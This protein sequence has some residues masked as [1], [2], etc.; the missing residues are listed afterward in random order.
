MFVLQRVKASRR[1]KEVV[2]S[3]FRRK[4][5]TKKNE[6]MNH[7]SPQSQPQKPQK[8]KVFVQYNLCSIIF[9]V[10]KV[11]TNGDSRSL[12][13]D[14]LQIYTRKVVLTFWLFS[15]INFSMLLLLRSAF[16]SIVNTTWFLVGVFENK[17]G[18]GPS[19]HPAQVQTGKVL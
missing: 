12:D 1:S 3:T 19:R 15:L 14:M 18:R 7:L 6:Q 10:F 8:A 9:R 17:S 5:M 4:R 11:A 13:S 16:F 2:T